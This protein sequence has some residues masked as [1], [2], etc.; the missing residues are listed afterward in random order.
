MDYGLKIMRLVSR[1]LECPL[2]F[3]KQ[4]GGGGKKFKTIM[5]GCFFSSRTGA[6]N[7]EWHKGSVTHV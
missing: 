2:G 6:K 3:I 7:Y 5:Q 1:S 4:P